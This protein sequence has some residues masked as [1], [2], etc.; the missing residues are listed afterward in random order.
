MFLSIPKHVNSTAKL[1]IETRLVWAR[2][3]V[4]GYI[5]KDYHLSIERFPKS[6]SGCKVTPSDTI[7][8]EKY[9]LRRVRRLP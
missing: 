6:W 7:G 3:K 5:R 1:Q 2:L 8:V 4:T 9:F